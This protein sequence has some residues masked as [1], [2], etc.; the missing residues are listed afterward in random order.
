MGKT[1]RIAAAS[2]PARLLL[3]AALLF[4]A[5]A[6]TEEPPRALVRIQADSGQSVWQGEKYS[7]YVE[8]LSDTWFSG[9]PRFDLPDARAGILYKLQ[10]RPVLGSMALHGQT[11]TTQLHEFWFF[12]QVAGPVTVDEIAVHFSTA[13]PSGRAPQQ[14][15]LKTKPLTFEVRQIPGSSSG[16]TLISTN[17]L[18]VRQNWQPQSPDSMVGDVFTRTIVMKAD[19]LAGIFLPEIVPGNIEGISIYPE[20]PEV[21]D[22]TERGEAT[23][24]RK[25]MFTYLFE[26]EGNYVIEDIHLR[27]WN[28]AKEQ[29]ETIDLPGLKVKTTLN[30]NYQQPASGALVKRDINLKLYTLLLAAV[31]IFLYFGKQLMALLTFRLSRLQLQY[32]QSEYALFRKLASS[33]SSNEPLDAYNSLYWWMKKR[34]PRHSLTISHLGEENDRK[35]LVQEIETLD[36]VLFRQKQNSSPWQGKKLLKELSILRKKHP[37]APARKDQKTLPITLNN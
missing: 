21:S 34:H 28:T 8:L 33:C 23:G 27:W 32:S 16:E 14:H 6:W 30:P 25:E 22:R 13:A 35:N 18:E 2:S 37:P 3:L 11:Y 1:Q 12:P 9:S 10:E 29:I 19:N 15:S 31:L 4:P 5:A 26:K 36:G 17:H 24:I 20:A 7:F